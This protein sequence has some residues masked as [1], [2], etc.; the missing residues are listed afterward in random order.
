MRTMR[1]E[2]L[3]QWGRED[4]VHDLLTIQ[5]D[6][7]CYAVFAHGDELRRFSNASDLSRYLAGWR[8]GQLASESDD[9]HHDW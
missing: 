1:T 6:V 3:R 9:D 8:E 2:E 7:G 4:A 5:I